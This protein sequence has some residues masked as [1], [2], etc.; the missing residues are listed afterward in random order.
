MTDEEIVELLKSSYAF[1]KYFSAENQEEAL[2]KISALSPE[3]KRALVEKLVEEEEN[4]GDVEAKKSAIM[5]NFNNEATQISAS[6][7]KELITEI[8]KKEKENSLNQI[9]SQINN[10]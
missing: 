2:K 8:E 3:Q 5:G 6:H 4:L 7:Q 1:N 9:N 10:L